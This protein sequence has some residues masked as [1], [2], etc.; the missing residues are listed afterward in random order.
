MHFSIFCE[1]VRSL[2]IIHFEEIRLII[3]QMKVHNFKF[4]HHTYDIY[5]FNYRKKSLIKFI[6]Y[7]INL[8]LL[9]L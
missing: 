1:I 7:R 4:I 9:L 3:D 2:K 8:F 5:N 6:I